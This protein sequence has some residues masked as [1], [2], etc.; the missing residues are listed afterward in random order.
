MHWFNPFLLCL[1]SLVFKSLNET[2][3]KTSSNP[4]C[5]HEV[6]LTAR[7]NANTLRERVSRIKL[8]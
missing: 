4:K 2:K 7:Q 5:M 6:L 3:I 1:H 8:V